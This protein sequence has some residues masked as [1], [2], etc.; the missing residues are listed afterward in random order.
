M[1]AKGLGRAK[2]SAVALHVEI[3]P[4]NCISGSQ[5]ILHTRGLMPCWR[6]VFCTF[7][8]CMSFHTAR[9]KVRTHGSAMA[10]PVYK[11]TYVVTAGTA[12][13][14]QLRTHAPQQTAYTAAM[15]YSIT[16]SARASIVGGIVIPRASRYWIKFVHRAKYKSKPHAIAINTNQ[17]AIFPNLGTCL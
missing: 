15:I 2:T 4:S 1:T 16:S 14:C 12:V 10:R 5:I 11:R 7:R 6:I 9:V 13:E 8:G 3:S 17:I